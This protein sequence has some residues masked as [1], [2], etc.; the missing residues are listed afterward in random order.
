VKA[1]SRRADRCWWAVKDE[2]CRFTPVRHRR[3]LGAATFP[4]VLAEGRAAFARGDHATARADA[5]KVIDA[6]AKAPGQGRTR[7]APRA[8]R[9]PAAGDRHHAA[10]APAARVA[11]PPPRGRCDRFAAVASPTPRRS[12]HRGRSDSE[13]APT[14]NPSRTLISD[15]LSEAVVAPRARQQ[16]PG[17]PVQAQGGRGPSGHDRPTHHRRAGHRGLTEPYRPPTTPTPIAQRQTTGP[18]G[19]CRHCRS[20][21]PPAGTRL[22]VTS[23]TSS[24]MACCR[25]RVEEGHQAVV[26]VLQECG[27]RVQLVRMCV[28]PTGAHHHHWVPASAASSWA[29]T[30][31]GLRQSLRTR[32]FGA[33]VGRADPPSPSKVVHGLQRARNR[34]PGLTHEAVTTTAHGCQP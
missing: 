14:P 8:R 23:S 18:V 26:Q 10:R 1:R 34:L 7:G 31:R 9:P 22:V 32:A 20:P 21:R 2:R 27:L 12:R 11:G 6:I 4:A 33:T 25:D 24:P 28:K 16:R 17:Q 19:R 30:G 13:D 5:Q 3:P 15:A 29:A